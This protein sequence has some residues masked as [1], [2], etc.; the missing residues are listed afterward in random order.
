MPGPTAHE[1]DEEDPAAI[2]ECR[3]LLNKPK[4]QSRVDLPE[5]P[6][7]V[8]PMFLLAPILIIVSATLIRF[9][10]HLMQKGQFPYPLVL[11]FLHTVFCSLFCS[12]LIILVPSLFPGLTDPEKKVEVTAA[13]Y[14]TQVLPITGFF[15]T[16]LITSNMAYK[17]CTVAF[18]QMMKESNIVTVYAFSILGGRETF[19]VVQIAVLVTMMLA[20]WMC[21]KGEM[22]LSVIGCALQATSCI[23][24]SAKTVMQ[25]LLVSGTGKK[26]DP[27]SAVLIVMPVCSLLLGA[28]IWLTLIELIAIPGIELPSVQDFVRNQWELAANIVIAF[29]LN[30]VIA[31]FLKCCSPITLILTGNVKDIAIVGMS[32]LVMHEPIS[33]LQRIAFALQI[34]LVFL[35]SALKQNPRFLDVRFHLQKDLK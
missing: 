23:A 8:L 9:N 26:L 6:G 35:W 25:S 15:C 31:V 29:V 16:A 12:V 21:V 13:Y 22:H 27:L 24:E 18:L 19:S 4:E 17:F 20:T 32:S 1:D 28:I 10:Q 2:S 34:S 14:K 7:S 33:R 11:V 3:P 5:A 30:V